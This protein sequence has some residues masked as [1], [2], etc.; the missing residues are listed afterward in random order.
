MYLALT[1]Q[2][3]PTWHPVVRGGIYFQVQLKTYDARRSRQPTKD[4]HTEAQH[5]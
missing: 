1:L 4:T 3:Y 5:L 2:A